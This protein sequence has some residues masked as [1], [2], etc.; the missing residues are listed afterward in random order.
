MPFKFYQLFPIAKTQAYFPLNGEK[1]DTNTERI[2]N[3]EM[4]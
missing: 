2:G 4:K 3:S 1:H